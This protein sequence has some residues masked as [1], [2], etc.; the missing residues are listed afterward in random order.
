MDTDRLALISDQRCQS[1]QSL[2]PTTEWRL[3]KKGHDDTFLESK[4][5]ITL[6]A[7]FV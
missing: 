6:E 1:D 2:D 5:I 7:S 4:L 3:I